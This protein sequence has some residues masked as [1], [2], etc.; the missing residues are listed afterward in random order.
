[1]HDHRHAADDD[2]L[3]GEDDSDVVKGPQDDD[4]VEG[5]DQND[6]LYGGQR[7]DDIGENFGPVGEGGNDF[8]KSRDNVSGNDTLYP[9]PGTDTCAIDAGDTISGTCDL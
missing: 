8:L 9:D 3:E 6:K 4:V 5:E 1:M 2:S 7:D